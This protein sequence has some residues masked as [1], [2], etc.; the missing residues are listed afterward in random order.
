MKEIRPELETGDGGPCRCDSNEQL[1]SGREVR[2][3]AFLQRRQTR[4]YVSKNTV[5]WYS[6]GVFEL[7]K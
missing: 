2:K 5:P 1:V 6:I 4:N 7:V 3:A